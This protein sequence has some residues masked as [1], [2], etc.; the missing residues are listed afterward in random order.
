[1]TLQALVGLFYIYIYIYY[2][3]FNLRDD[4]P[5]A[6]RTNVDTLGGGAVRSYKPLSR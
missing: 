5:A 2:S 3:F 1:M 6:F 4:R